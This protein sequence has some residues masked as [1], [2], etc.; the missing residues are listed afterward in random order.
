MVMVQTMDQSAFWTRAALTP[1]VVIHS[2]GFTELGRLVALNFHDALNRRP[3]I[4]CIWRMLF[5]P[6]DPE[7]LPPPSIPFFSVHP[8]PPLGN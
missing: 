4:V 2:N 8:L 5:K 3:L 6:K 1:P 7:P